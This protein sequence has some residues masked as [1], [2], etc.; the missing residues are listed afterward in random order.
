MKAFFI[1]ASCNLF[2]GPLLVKK[3]TIK[4]TTYSV[5]AFDEWAL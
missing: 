3:P 4:N 1:C 2:I 5:L